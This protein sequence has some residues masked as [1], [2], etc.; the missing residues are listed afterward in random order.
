MTT[1]ETA[2]VPPGFAVLPPHAHRRTCP[3]QHVNLQMGGSR[4]PLSGSDRSRVTVHE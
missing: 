1:D 3:V 2:S 4:P